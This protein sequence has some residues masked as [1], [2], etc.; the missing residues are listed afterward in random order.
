MRFTDN[1]DQVL[2][3]HVA[4]NS[5]NLNKAFK[6]AAIETGR[7]K[8]SM[9][10]RWYYHLVP[11][12]EAANARRRNRQGATARDLALKPYFDKIRAKSKYV[13]NRKNI[14]DV[15]PVVAIAKTATKLAKVQAQ[16][17]KTDRSLSETVRL[18]A[19]LNGLKK[20]IG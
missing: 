11:E 4:V 20:L 15:D 18:R 10:A 1:E 2:L 17:R 16:K 7:S 14:W 12:W 6:D 9:Q 5:G 8:A 13:P 19:R 3:K